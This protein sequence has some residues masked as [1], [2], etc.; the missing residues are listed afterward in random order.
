MSKVEHIELS[1]DD[2]NGA[3]AFYSK[4]FK[5]K[6]TSNPNPGG[7]GEYLMFRT[8]NGGGGITAKMMPGQPTAWL[9][10]FTVKSVKATRDAAT[11]AGAAV[12]ADYM[13]IGDMGAIAVLADPTGGAFGLWEPGKAAPAPVKK[14]APKKAAKKAAP[15]KR[16]APKKKAAKK[17]R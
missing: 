8:E 10:Y 11:A 9:P 14:A 13:A 15:K 4:L 3:R 7:Q 5:W 2:P 12:H 6:F 17:R 1:T 16:A